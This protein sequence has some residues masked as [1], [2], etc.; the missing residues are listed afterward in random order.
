MYGIGR[1]ILV[2]AGG[3]RLSQCITDDTYMMATDPGVCGN[4]HTLTRIAH[5]ISEAGIIVSCCG[6]GMQIGGTHSLMMVYGMM[7][8]KIVGPVG[9]AWL[10]KDMK[11]TLPFAVTEPIEV[12]VNGFGTF[13]FDSVIYD[14]TGC[15]VVSL[16]GRGGLGV[17]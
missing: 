15:V 6:R 10:P 12:H 7:L 5:G 17:T 16:Q 13:L 2:Y 14:S 11:V 9:V 3:H 4:Q 1:S 8:G